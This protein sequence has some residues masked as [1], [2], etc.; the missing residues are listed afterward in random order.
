M[1]YMY[2]SDTCIHVVKI[3][4]QNYG[5]SRWKNNYL[6]ISLYTKI[7]HCVSLDLMCTSP[8]L[9][10]LFL[11]HCNVRHVCIS[12]IFVGNPIR[13]RFVT[14]RRTSTGTMWNPWCP[15]SARYNDVNKVS[16]YYTH[17]NRD[18]V[19]SLVSGLGTLQRCEQGYIRLPT[20]WAD[21]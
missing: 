19:E 17:I 7:V 18:D 10:C 6:E 12:N 15:D 11:T 9:H 21:I 8:W 16:Y 5:E 2:R 13:S 14:C 20:Y 1:K 4:D 3:G